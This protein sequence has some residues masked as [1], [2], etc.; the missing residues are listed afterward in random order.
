[1]MKSIF[2]VDADVSKETIS[3]VEE[4]EIET[5]YE[6]NDLSLLKSY[7]SYKDFK[8]IM[9]S[10]T[11][12]KEFCKKYLTYIERYGI[13][14]KKNMLFSKIKT[15]FQNSAFFRETLQYKDDTGEDLEYEISMI[16]MDLKGRIKGTLQ[17]VNTLEERAQMDILD[18]SKKVGYDKELIIL[19]DLIVM[20]AQ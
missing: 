8:D 16:I 14:F 9:E 18:I 12:V 2:V 17:K 10:L 7:F 3:L 11:N 15:L 20:L 1:M 4:M 5:E 19:D 13:N 6:I